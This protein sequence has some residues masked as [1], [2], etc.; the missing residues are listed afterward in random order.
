VGV[1]DAETFYKGYGEENDWC[2]RS[3]KMG[4]R[5]VQVENMFVYHKHGAS[6]PSEDKKRY[7][8]RN[9]KLLNQMHPNYDADVQKYL[10]ADPAFRLRQ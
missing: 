1:L 5:N 10:K 9:L 3:I 4:Y 8:E 2:Q 6:F 7:I